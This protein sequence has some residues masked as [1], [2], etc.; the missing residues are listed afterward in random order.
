MSLKTRADYKFRYFYND[1]INNLKYFLLELVRKLTFSD[2]R[3]K[4]IMNILKLNNI[5]RISELNSKEIIEI[6]NESGK[7]KIQNDNLHTE[8]FNLK[9]RI[10]ILK[11]ENIGLR[12]LNIYFIDQK[13][14]NFQDK[15]YI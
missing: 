12:D 8:N 9:T 7:L 15:L 2:Y 10:K 4:A 13:I 11:I 1:Q 14:I 3:L 5:K 6:N